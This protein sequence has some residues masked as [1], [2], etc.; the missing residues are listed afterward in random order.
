[1][2]WKYRRKKSKKYQCLLCE[3]KKY[4]IWNIQWKWNNVFKL[5]KSVLNICEINRVVKPMK[6]AEMRSWEASRNT[7]AEVKYNEI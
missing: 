3:K 4:S 7:E 2:K 5:K 1:M 6:E